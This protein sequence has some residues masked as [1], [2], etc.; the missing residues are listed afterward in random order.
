MIEGI[1]INRF[2]MALTG[3]VLSSIDNYWGVVVDTPPQPAP[4]V[5]VHGGTLDA[6]LGPCQG[7]LLQ[8]S[9]VDLQRLYE[10]GHM[11][12]WDSANLDTFMKP[13]GGP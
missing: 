6:P 11:G 10:A 13:N 12:V 2:K 8:G 3:S 5:G 9:I 1:N 4:T 7:L